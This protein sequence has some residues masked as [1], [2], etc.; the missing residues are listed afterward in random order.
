M[1]SLI[2]AVLVSPAFSAPVARSSHTVVSPCQDDAA[3]LCPGL[4][5]AAKV[6]CLETN[7]ARESFV[8][9]SFIKDRKGRARYARIQNPV[10]RAD[11]AAYCSQYTEW[12][13][14]RACLWDDVRVS[15]GC[16]T[17]LHHK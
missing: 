1:L 3:R 6:S 17:V 5:G 7:E 8:C 13:D 14:R 16:K 10:C 11:I 9:K 12:V 15:S 4:S 2:L